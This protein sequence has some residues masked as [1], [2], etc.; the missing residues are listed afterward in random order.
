MST[1]SE[2]SEVTKGVSSA[3]HLPCKKMFGGWGSKLFVERGNL[4]L[5]ILVERICRQGSGAVVGFF[6][7]SCGL[8][9]MRGETKNRGERL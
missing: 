9:W 8:F 7:M 1:P 5:F 6:G 3:C 2:E 4:R